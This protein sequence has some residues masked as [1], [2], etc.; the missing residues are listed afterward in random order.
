LAKSRLNSDFPDVYGNENLSPVSF[1][2]AF[3]R[4]EKHFA[5]PALPVLCFD[6]ATFSKS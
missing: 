5:M 3:F 4:K 6:I 1:A 2:S